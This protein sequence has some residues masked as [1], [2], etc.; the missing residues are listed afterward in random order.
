MRRTDAALGQTVEQKRNTD[1]SEERKASFRLKYI[2][3][4]AHE[5]SEIKCAKSSKHPLVKQNSLN[6]R[7]GFSREQKKKKQMAG[8]RVKFF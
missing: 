4:Q 2:L 7:P 8:K 6:T 1:E 5:N 3:A